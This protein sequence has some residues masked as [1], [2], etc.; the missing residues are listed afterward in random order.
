MEALW[1]T[2][3]QVCVVSRKWQQT[4]L[5]L[6]VLRNVEELN[7]EAMNGTD[8]PFEG[9]IEVKFKLAGDYTTADELTVP[10]LLRRKDQEY[11]IVGLNVIEEIL[12]QHSENHQAASNII[13]QSF[14]SVHHTQVGALV[15]LI[16]STSQD[17]GTS[18]VKVGK[19]DVMLCCQK[20]RQRKLSVK[21][22]SGLF[23]RECR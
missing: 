20:E 23:Q 9:W 13:Q 18:A 4:H 7:L 2:G 17:T 21:F 6:K 11:P 14:P 8:I 5:P 16:Q 1:D 22:T 15:N 19:R 12:S 3:S 10:V